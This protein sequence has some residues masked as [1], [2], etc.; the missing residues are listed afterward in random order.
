[1]LVIAQ[2]RLDEAKAPSDRCSEPRILTRRRMEGQDFLCQRVLSKLDER[3]TRQISQERGLSRGEL[4]ACEQVHQG[5]RGAGQVHGRA[6]EEAFKSSAGLCRL[7][8]FRPGS[9]ELRFEGRCSRT[10]PLKARNVEEDPKVAGPL[11]RGKRGQGILWKP[12]GLHH[13]PG[14]V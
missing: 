5:L 10:I 7:L 14:K 3:Q 6:R 13:G 1:R 4:P 9:S 12:P 8:G 11:R 2:L